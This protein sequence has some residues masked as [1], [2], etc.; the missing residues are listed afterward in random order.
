MLGCAGI[1]FAITVLPE[2]L[3]EKFKRKR[4]DTPA[5]A[6]KEK[7]IRIAVG[8]LVMFPLMAFAWPAV[9]GER[10]DA[11]WVIISAITA[12]IAVAIADYLTEKQKERKRRNSQEPQRMQSRKN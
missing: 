7:W 2:Y 8:T 4:A 12:P 11:A 9:K 10:A 1:A 3:I 6:V 5:I